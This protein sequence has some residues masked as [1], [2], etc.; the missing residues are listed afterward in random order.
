[1]SEEQEAKIGR[2]EGLEQSS[3]RPANVPLYLWI[4]RQMPIPA[5]E[6]QYFLRAFIDAAGINVVGAFLVANLRPELRRL[7]PKP[8]KG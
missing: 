4:S 8:L 5:C 3:Q 2:R 1:V 6:T 7:E